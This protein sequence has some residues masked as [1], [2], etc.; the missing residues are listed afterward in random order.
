MFHGRIRGKFSTLRI[1]ISNI[2]YSKNI[3]NIRGEKIN[4]LGKFFHI[5]E[6]LRFFRIYSIYYIM[7]SYPRPEYRQ[8]VFSVPD[9]G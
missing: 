9:I 8:P 2:T 1:L 6:K 3:I 4:R 7:F 5:K